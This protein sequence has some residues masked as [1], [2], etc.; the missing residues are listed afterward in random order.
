[1]TVPQAV[2]VNKLIFDQLIMCVIFVTEKTYYKNSNYNK[3]LKIIKV[4]W[5]YFKFYN[6]ISNNVFFFRTL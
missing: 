1:M 2:E 3:V 5:C 4:Y 6:L